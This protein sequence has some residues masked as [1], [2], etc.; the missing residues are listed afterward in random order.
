MIG[1]A[2]LVPTTVMERKTAL[3]EKGDPRRVT[4]DSLT[5][6]IDGRQ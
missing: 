2:G 1:I 5:A 3:A 4:R 6:V